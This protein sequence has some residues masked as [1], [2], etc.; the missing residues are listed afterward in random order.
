MLKL[1]YTETGFHLERSSE[2]LDEIVTQWVLLIMGLGRKLVVTPGTATLLF[3]LH[4]PEIKDLKTTAPVKSGKISLELCDTEWMEVSLQGF[5]IASDR[6]DI[7]G[8]FLVD[9][10]DGAPGLQANSTEELLLKLW[11]VHSEG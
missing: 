7:E 3:P 4:L 10:Q 1:T 8:V 11:K 2:S 6:E 5:W 9:L